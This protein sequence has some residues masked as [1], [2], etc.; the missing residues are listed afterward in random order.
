MKITVVQSSFYPGEIK[1]NYKK[2]V[3]FYKK[4]LEDKSEIMI[5]PLDSIAGFEAKDL[6]IKE[7]YIE[8]CNKI[9]N[10]I[11]VQ[12][13]DCGI[14]YDVPQ[15]ESG[16]VYRAFFFVKNGNIL[17]ASKK[18]SHI[19]D[20]SRII[21]Y[22]GLNILMCAAH[23]LS[24]LP[25]I[26]GVHYDVCVVLDT[27]PFE[28]DKSANFKT[29][30]QTK[31]SKITDYAIYVNQAG[32]VEE[33]ILQGN[34][35]VFRKKQNELF[36]RELAYFKKDILSIDLFSEF[37][38]KVFPRKGII[39]DAIIV[40]IKDY[41]KRCGAKTAVVGLSG[42][43]DSAVV[44][45]LVVEA[46]GRQ[47]VFGIMMPSQFS[48]KHSLSDAIELA[49]NLKI[50]YETIPIEP[51][52]TTYNRQLSPLFKGLDFGLAEENLQARI[53]GSLLMAA[54]NKFGHLLL[55]T[56]NKSELACGYGTMYGDLCGGLSV[57]GDLY[58]RE[59]YELAHYIN[60]NKTIIPLSSIDKP[61]SAELRPNQKD[62]DS[63][64]DYDFIEKVLTI[65]LRF[66]QSK[67]SVISALCACQ[68]DEVKAILR[69][70][71]EKIFNLFYRNE[72]KRR[73]SPPILKLS[74]TSLQLDRKMPMIIKEY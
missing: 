34:S 17:F 47:N 21:E 44:L 64:P 53:R 56:S 13:K 31:L 61:P 26:K 19:L 63:L 40:G 62:S 24:K 36:V 67:K 70:N 59:V 71:I 52:Y 38:E 37:K 9:S 30:I 5:L 16:E 58:K 51:I 50:Y 25:N 2:I 43:I 22:N 45:P 46:L 28:N 33:Y 18:H 10:A 65:H 15:V 20:K 23:E 29:E 49:D 7:N 11:I 6:L 42:G 1:E 72:Y 73:Q 39:H 14:M 55:N 41:F 12:S 4:A 32:G 8:E 48:S 66:K 69:A 74:S 57:L 60:R 3:K 35:F 68:T 54:S 27:H